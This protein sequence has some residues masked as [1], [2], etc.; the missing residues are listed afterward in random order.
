MP[1]TPS[2]WQFLSDR[3]VSF[4]EDLAPAEDLADRRAS[5]GRRD[6]EERAEQSDRRHRLR[7]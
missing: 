6:R 1:C 5:P 4:C 2:V 7:R 3:N